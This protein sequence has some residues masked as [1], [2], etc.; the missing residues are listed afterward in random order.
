MANSERFWGLDPSSVAI[1]IRVATFEKLSIRHTCCRN[2]WR[3]GIDEQE[4]NNLNDEDAIRIKY[5][6]DLVPEFEAAFESMECDVSEFFETYWKDRMSEVLDELDGKPLTKENLQGIEDLG[7][8]LIF[9]DDESSVESEM[10]SVGYFME[11]LDRIA[12]GLGT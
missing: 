2:G 11:E 8:R 9:E 5:L 7:I 4:I 1:V 12:D 10:S 6:E 3:T